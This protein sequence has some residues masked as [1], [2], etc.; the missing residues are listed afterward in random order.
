[1][2]SN[3]ALCVTKQFMRKWN[4]K[5]KSIISKRK[6]TMFDLTGKKGSNNKIGHTSLNTLNLH[7]IQFILKS[8]LH[9]IYN[10][11]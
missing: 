10:S 11:G 5:E 7:L 4:D 6:N 1:M 3:V 9:L 8:T 2:I